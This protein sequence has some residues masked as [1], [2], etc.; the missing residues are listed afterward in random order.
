MSHCKALEFPNSIKL[1]VYFLKDVQGLWLPLL[2]PMC[3]GSGSS[4]M[5]CIIN[6]TD[7]NRFPHYL[8]WDN[9]CVAITNGTQLLGWWSL[10]VFILRK[11]VWKSQHKKPARY[12]FITSTLT[13]G[14]V[15]TFFLITL[16]NDLC[17]V[18]M[19]ES[20]TGHN[21]CQPLPQGKIWRKK[22]PTLILPKLHIKKSP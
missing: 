22:N 17:T 12:S 1:W 13:S 2:V 11:F 6:I 15:I 14:K 3:R 8:I 4:S 21:K 18:L 16:S 10:Q 7:K 5:T 9:Y 19:H 20:S